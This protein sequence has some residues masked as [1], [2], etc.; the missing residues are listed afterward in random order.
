MSQEE[1]ELRTNGRG[2][3]PPIGVRDLPAPALTSHAR[4]A[5]IPPGRSRDSTCPAGAGHGHESSTG[6]LAHLPHLMRMVEACSAPAAR[7]A[8]FF[9]PHCGPRITK[10]HSAAACAAPAQSSS[11]ALIGYD[12]MT[13]FHHAAYAASYTAHSATW[14]AMPLATSGT[15]P[16]RQ[17]LDMLNG[18]LQEQ[19]RESRREISFACDAIMYE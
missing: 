4:R 16:T 6:R 9:R 8:A 18:G 3:G 17:L 12:G 5:S 7:G 14:Q 15:V 19:A 2:P 11:A 1:G 10:V 13:L